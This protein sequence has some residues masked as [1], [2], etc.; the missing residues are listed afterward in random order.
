MTTALAIAATLLALAALAAWILAIRTSYRI[1][2]LRAPGAPR[3]LLF[4]NIV[5]SLF[6]SDASS[7]AEAPLRKQLRLRLAIAI[8]CFIALG[9][10]SF[11]LPLLTPPTR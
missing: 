3:R 10:L 4:T 9:A 5:A 8:A 6:R 11:T 7:E 1:E 2:R